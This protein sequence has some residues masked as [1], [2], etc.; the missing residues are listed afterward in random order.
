MVSGSLS[1]PNRSFDGAGPSS[2]T[3]GVLSKRTHSKNI[4][5]DETDAGRNSARVG[6]LKNY[7]FV[8]V[9]E[10]PDSASFIALFASPIVLA[11]PMTLPLPK[12]NT[13]PTR[14]ATIATS[15]PLISSVSPPL[16]PLTSLRVCELPP[17]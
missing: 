7:S 17:V 3:H 2:S 15:I 14:A 8:A 5:I 13:A 12:K 10:V 9:S 1:S 11:Q 4:R 16:Q 6:L